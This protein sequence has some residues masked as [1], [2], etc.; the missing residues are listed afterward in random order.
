MRWSPQFSRIELKILTQTLS[1]ILNRSDILQV[2]NPPTL[3]LQSVRRTGTTC[4]STGMVV[5]HRH[6]IKVGQNIVVLARMI[7]NSAFTHT[8]IIGTH[9]AACYYVVIVTV[10]DSRGKVTFLILTRMNITKDNEPRKINVL[11]KSLQE[12]WLDLRSS[13]EWSAR[14]VDMSHTGWAD[15]LIHMH[16]KFVIPRSQACYYTQ[17]MPYIYSTVIMTFPVFSISIVYIKKQHLV[18]VPKALPD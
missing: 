6:T 5:M 17:I 11:L 9:L 10:W 18:P 7:G 1:V 2:T 4:L 3:S 8:E 14:S 16:P 15:I 12:C 13:H